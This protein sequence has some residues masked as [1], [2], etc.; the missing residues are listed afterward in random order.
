MFPPP[1]PQTASVLPFHGTHREQGVYW[2][3]QRLLRLSQ[4]LIVIDPFLVLGC[5]DKLF[6]SWRLLWK[7][8][9]GR[10]IERG[11][12]LP[13]VGA[14]VISA[15]HARS[16]A[17]RW[18]SWSCAFSPTLSPSHLLYPGLCCYGNWELLWVQLHLST[19]KPLVRGWFPQT[20]YTRAQTHTLKS[21]KSYRIKGW[22]F[23][24]LWILIILL[25]FY[26]PIRMVPSFDYRGCQ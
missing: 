16:A 9:R 5:K 10:Q 17:M 7:P 11:P 22:T 20:V 18:L 15:A 2:G 1:H 23:Y 8:G 25:V 21:G 26:Q 3:E 19:L 6:S 12:L 13:G 4:K 24:L 14:A